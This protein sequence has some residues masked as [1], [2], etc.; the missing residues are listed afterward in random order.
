[1][2]GHVNGMTNDEEHVFMRDDP[3][4][5]HERGQMNPSY[6]G[7]ITYTRVGVA[8]GELPWHW[9]QFIGAVTCIV[10]LVHHPQCLIMTTTQM[11]LIPCAVL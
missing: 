1:M 8:G 3:S 7:F 11:L 10:V 5:I 6:Y 4:R 2:V 9:Q